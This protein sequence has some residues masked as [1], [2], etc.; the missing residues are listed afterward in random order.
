MGRVLEVYVDGVSLEPVG[1][2]GNKF[3]SKRGAE[4]RR[5]CTFKGIRNLI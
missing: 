1:K 2:K 5:G 3:T 4:W